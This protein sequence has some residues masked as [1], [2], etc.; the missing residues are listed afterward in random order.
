MTAQ[1]IAK[2]I[3]RSGVCS[4]REAEKLIELGKVK[5]NGKVL[6]TPAIKVTEKD[7][8]EVNG[9]KIKPQEPTKLWLFNKPKGCITSR[10]DPEG[11]K[12]VFDFLSE[13]LPYLIAIGRLDY[14]TEGLLMFTND[15]DFAREIEL[16]STGWKRVYKVRAYGKINKNKLDILTKGAK[17]DGV[18]YAPAVVD[19][20]RSKSDNHWLIMTITEGKN[21][22]IKNMLSF[23][24]LEVN[25]LI[26]IS[27]GDYKLEDLKSG[28]IKQVEIS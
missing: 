8:I 12:T 21:R 7:I 9:N 26:R 4:R 2:V 10:K 15:G 24:G 1:R 22:E 6:D 23:C 18:K 28:E 11:R 5:L 19:I 27:Y 25:R 14:N 20:D 17:I 16:P 3:A 13:E